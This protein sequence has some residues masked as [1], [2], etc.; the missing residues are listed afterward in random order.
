LQ[1]LSDNFSAEV[2]ALKD[3]ACFNPEPLVVWRRMAHGYSSG[4]SSQWPKMFGIIEKAVRLM[5]NDFGAYFPSSYVD[6]WTRRQ[7]LALLQAPG[8]I[9]RDALKELKK[10]LPSRSLLDHLFF[11]GLLPLKAYLFLDKT[12]H[13]KL[14]M[15]KRRWK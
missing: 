3:G 4:V 7:L 12:A 15:V 14:D 5:K 6:L 10:R 11:A 1:S 2:M 13:Q 8:E 9:D